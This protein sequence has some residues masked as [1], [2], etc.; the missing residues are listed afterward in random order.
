MK[1]DP[2]L[3]PHLALAQNVRQVVLAIPPGKV[4]PYS[5]VALLAGFPGRARQVGKLMGQLKGVPWWRVLRADRSFAE[6]LASQ[7]ARRLR[8]EGV[9]VRGKRVPLSAV[10]SVPEMEGHLRANR[11]R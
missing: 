10:A 4:L 3:K 6:H 2:A 5:R 11:K 1:R 8:R 9:E 7:Q